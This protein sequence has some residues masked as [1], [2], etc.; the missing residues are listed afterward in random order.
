ML[1]KLYNYDNNT[2][3]YWI[4][5][6]TPELLVTVLSGD[7]VVSLYNADGKQF[8]CLDPRHDDR[9][10]D[11]FDGEYRVKNADFEKWMQRTSSY[12]ENWISWEERLKNRFGRWKL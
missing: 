12:D 10:H 9:Y 5:D 7:E 8:G 11:Y 3:R 2:Y 4:P 1:I 6:D